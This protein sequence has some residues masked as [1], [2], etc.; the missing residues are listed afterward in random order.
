MKSITDDFPE[1]L[2]L[3]EAAQCLRLGIRRHSL[4][5]SSFKLYEIH[6]VEKIN[7]NKELS[8]KK[9][10]AKNIS[11]FCLSFKFELWV[12]N[13]EVISIIDP[14]LH[15]ENLKTIGGVKI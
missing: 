12:W 13:R 11:I 8:S 9:F 5:A 1:L 4:I 10:H 15:M 14:K 3:P 7:R 6:N 2:V